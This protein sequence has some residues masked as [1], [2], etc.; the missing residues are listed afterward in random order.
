MQANWQR[1]WS[2]CRQ[3]DLMQC[4]LPNWAHP[5]L[6]AK[7]LDA[8]IRQVLMPYCPGGSHGWQFWMKHKN[9]N[10]TQLLPSFLT[11]DRHKKAKQFRD[12]K[13]TLYSH[14][15]CDKLDT[16]V[17]HYYLS[18]RAQLHFELSNV[19]NGQKFD[20][21]LTLNKAPKNLWAKYGP[22]A[23]KLLRLSR[24]PSL[25]GT[26]A[27]LLWVPMAC[28]TSW[29]KKAWN[30][31]IESIAPSKR[32]KGHHRTRCAWPGTIWTHVLPCIHAS[33]PQVKDLNSTLWSQEGR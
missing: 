25:T 17:K 21:L 33:G 13:Q 16:N 19:V 8:A 1:F 5:W 26:L 4:T 14:H 12:P 23:V 30:S 10:K 18:W 20:K 15:W 11:V 2:P 9:T 27:G 29:I 32:I 28:Q 6:D 31:L 24:Q 3:G 22:I 7:P